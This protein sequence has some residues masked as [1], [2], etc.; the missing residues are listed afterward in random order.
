MISWSL[1][2][3]SILRY[4]WVQVKDDVY[5]PKKLNFFYRDFALCERFLEKKKSKK[6]LDTVFGMRYL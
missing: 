1:L 4:I 5:L 3:N 2:K 6:K